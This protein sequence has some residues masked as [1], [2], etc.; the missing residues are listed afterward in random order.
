MARELIGPALPPGF[1]RCAEADPDEDF[2]QGKGAKRRP[3][4]STAPGLPRVLR[5]TPLP[6]ASSPSRSIP[7]RA[8][9]EFRGR[10]PVPL[11][12]YTKDVW[13]G[14]KEVGGCPPRFTSAPRQ[15]AG[16]GMTTT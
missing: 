6:L 12:G 16:R 7:F 11:R 13:Q 4:G 8:G 2:S 1:P 10:L 14:R 5:S 3:A 9:L 15:V